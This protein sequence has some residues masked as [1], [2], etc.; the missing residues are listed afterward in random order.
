ML[1]KVDTIRYVIPQTLMLNEKYSFFLLL[2]MSYIF[3]N[4][5][6]DIILQNRS[7]FVFIYL[8]KYASIEIY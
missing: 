3:N 4:Y 2:E 1:Q 6:V 7:A 8:F 5:S